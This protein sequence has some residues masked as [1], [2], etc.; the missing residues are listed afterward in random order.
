MLL[1]ACDG[2]IQQSALLLEFTHRVGTHRTGEDILL[3]TH[4][5]HRGELQTLG[6]VDGHQCHLVVLVALL[7]VK[8]R[9]QRHLLQEIRQEYLVAHI[10]LPTAL[11]E[12]LH[13]TQELLQVLLSRDVLR[14]APGID[15]LADARVHDDVVSQ[16]VG[17]FSRNA[18]YPTLNQFTKVLY[19]RHRALAHLHGEQHRLLD[20]LPQTDAVGLCRLDNLTNSRISDAS[21]RI[22]DDTLEGLLVV[23]IGYQTEVGY[24]VLDL[25]T[26]IEAQSAIDT[27]R[28]IVLEHLFLKRTALRVGAIQ[29]G[30]VAPVGML[31]P[32]QPLDVLT[33]DDG[34]LLV[35]VGRLQLQ[36]LTVLILREHILRDLPLIP[37]DQRIGRLH[38]QLRRAVV[39]LQL[40]E[41]RLPIQVLEVQDIVDIR[42]SER[43]DALRVITHH[44]HHLA[45]LGQLIH[46]RLLRIVRVLILIHQYELE[47]IDIFL[48]H[49]LVILEED[50]RLNQ[51]IVEVHRIG[52]P[53]P[54]RVPYIYIGHLRA[55]LHRV[56]LR[57]GTLGIGLG[58]HQVVLGHRDTVGH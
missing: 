38:D 4:D 34:L 51:Q 1:S 39:L 46:N 32:A 11:H 23:R 53:A 18:T 14:I 27:V 19:L 26:L 44:T 16:C 8:I 31:L 29:D 58:Q 57:P 2:H 40:E 36:L 35:A 48:T 42:P 3:Q 9:Q 56:V 22:V 10:L 21:C 13:T 7:T 37:P 33:H 55:L 54:F 20:H 15:I 52:L 45:L 6:R 5:K 41:L 43:I 50:P 49:I 24:H 25:L 47:L 28:D 30:E 12:V 17:I